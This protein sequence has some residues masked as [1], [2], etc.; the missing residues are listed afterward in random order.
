MAGINAAAPGYKKILIQPRIGGGLTWVKSSYECSYG[1]IVSQWK[2]KEDKVR[3][4]VEIPP[5]TTAEIHV[6]GKPVVNVGPGK[7]TFTGQVYK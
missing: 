4:K 5:G 1:K 2:R 7:Y 6:P 3:M